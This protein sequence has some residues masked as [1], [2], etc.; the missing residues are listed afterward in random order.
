MPEQTQAILTRAQ[1]ALIGNYARLPVV[2]DRGEGAFLWDAD[3]KRYIDLF[4]GFGGAILGH[5]QPDLVRPCRS[6]RPGSGTSA[7]R[8]TPSRRPSWPSG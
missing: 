7:T 8:S 6:R 5:C 2:M 4:A 3:G 1:D